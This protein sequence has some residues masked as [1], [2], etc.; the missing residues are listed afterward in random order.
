MLSTVF[1][2]A[3]AGTLTWILV[4]SLFLSNVAAAQTPAYELKN[5]YWFDGA[6]FEPGIRYTVGDTLVSNKPDSV[7][8]TIDLN[9]GY[10]IPP[11]ADGH[12]HRPATKDRVFTDSRF[13]LD[14]GIFYIMNHGNISRYSGDFREQLSSTVTIDAVF[15]GGILSSPMSHSVELWQRLHSRGAFPDI[16][17]EELDGEAYFVIE[18]VSDLRERW[19]EILA[20]RPDFLKI[21][22]QFS[23][24][25]EQRKSDPQYFGYSGLDPSM[26]GEIVDRAHAAGLRVSAH[27]ETAEDFRVAVSAGVDI[28]AH[29]PGYDVDINDDINS[30][31]LQEQDASS[32]AEN[33][34]IV[35]TT[36]L[37]SQDRSEDQDEKYSRMMQNHRENLR[38]LSRAGVRLAIG[39]DQFSKHAVDEL[40][41][42]DT[43]GLFDNATLLRMICN[44]TPSAI[45]PNRSIG[46]L[47]D[48]AEASF[49]VLTNNPLD[50]ITAI[51]NIRLRV[52]GGVILAQE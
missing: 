17:E 42:L 50:D 37:L 41:H 47:V 25:Y 21:M 4:T 12:T 44:I 15:S 28:I 36:T 27:I 35:L 48:G 19:S 10:V 7:I 40:L 20:T 2:Q 29:L 16:D 13:F 51:R 34:T 49:L 52:K 45:Y 23:E 3:N 5:G 11:F 31:R 9:G 33:D 14:A 39:S 1:R 8:E 38:L 18:S 6:K 32:A 22:L 43:L 46:H 24:E 26:V 30:Y